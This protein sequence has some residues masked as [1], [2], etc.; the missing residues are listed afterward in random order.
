MMNRRD[1][2]LLGSL[3]V[4]GVSW[5]QE[6]YPD[7]P[8][9]IVL[10]FSAGGPTDLVARRLAERLTGILRQPVVVENKS[11][12]SGTIA[13]AEVARARPDGYT[14]MVATS[15]SHAI[16]ASLM[17]TPTFDPVEDYTPITLIG[18]VPMVM[19][20]HPG[21]RAQSLADLIALLRSEPSGSISYASSGA[22]G[23]AHF[24]AEL[25]MRQI[26]GVTMTQIPY[27]GAG[28]ALQDLLAGHVPIYIDTFATTLEHHRAGRLRI[29]ANFS[30]QRSPAAPEVPTA[31]E[32]GVP[33]M[34]A[35]TYNALLA[36]ASIPPGVMQTLFNAT[37]AVMA[38][39]VFQSFLTS[40]S[41]QPVPGIS[42]QETR[43]YMRAEL[44]KWRPIIRAT[45]M[46]ME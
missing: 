25:L 12:A 17:K 45:G 14:L 10:G 23:I 16:A 44:L 46:T 43:E 2:L 4:P 1:F 30:R 35:N 11:G 39:P 32:V 19:A 37:Q 28:P 24:T 8:I 15:S 31:I 18:E 9:R 21:F 34:I 27:R 3:W 6:S 20:V 26:G 29:I 36:P 42:S 41:V 5:A 38:D 7:R 40:V 13:A 33:D 22:G